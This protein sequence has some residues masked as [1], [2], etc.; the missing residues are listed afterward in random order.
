MAEDGSEDADVIASSVTHP[1]HGRWSQLVGDTK[2]RAKILPVL[3]DVEIAADTSHAADADQPGIQVEQ[4]PL[5]S[6]FTYSG[7]IMSQRNP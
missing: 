7:L 1:N 6:A 4:P 2:T 3:L 5:P